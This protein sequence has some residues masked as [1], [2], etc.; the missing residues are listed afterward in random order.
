[1]R[2]VGG[3]YRG[4]KLAEFNGEAIRPTADSV[5][6]SLFNIL[7]FK[8]AGS[9]FLDLYAGTGAIGI[10][11]LS[12]G[13]EAVVF[14]DRSKESVALINKN[15]TLLKIQNDVRVS[16]AEAETFLRL[17]EQKFDI[18]FLD[19]PYLNGVSPEVYERLPE[20][21]TE[22]GIVIYENEKPFDG[23]IAG[24]TLYNRRKYGRVHLSFFKKEG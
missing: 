17:T 20:I 11:A 8:V 19:P 18:V 13:A 14:N 4:R 10:E 7:Q 21:L 9:V 3:I 22:N 15:L 16:C 12:R 24:L 6:E 5:R 1:M 23:E 2:I